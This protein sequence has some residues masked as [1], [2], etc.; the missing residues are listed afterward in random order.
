M[1]IFALFLVAAA[2]CAQTFEVASIKVNSSGP[3]ASQFPFLN[4]GRLTAKNSP[5]RWI[6]EAA[7]D[8][9]PP[10]ITGPDWID[11]DRYD[12]EGRTPEGVPDTE[13]KSML[14]ALL[15]DRFKL[16]AHIEMREMPV[17]NLVVAKGGPKIKPFDPEHP[18][19][20][21]ARV[22]GASM[23]VGGFE[24]PRIA[25]ALA[26]TAGRPV[27]DKTGLQGRYFFAIQYSQ[28]GTNTETDGAPDL[29]GAVQQQL[30][31]KLEPAKA[32][33][34]ILVVDHLER[35]PTEN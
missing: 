28:L 14:Q 24:V 20:Q 23:L 3:S 19:Q 22:P 25:K 30:G 7:W 35:T 16:E 12:M 21:P 34:E 9:S 31:L 17:Y 1:R 4:Q 29:F 32:Q 33:V 15:K 13:I 10:Q 6:L 8:L 18:G 26:G 27:I 2:L 11:N 5:V